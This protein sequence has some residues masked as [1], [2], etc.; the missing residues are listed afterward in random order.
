[1]EKP[2][3]ED[4]KK[5]I[6]HKNSR[7]S[8]FVLKHK[9]LIPG[10][11]MDINAT[12]MNGLHSAWSNRYADA[13]KE[14]KETKKGP[15][16]SKRF[17]TVIW[18]EIYSSFMRRKKTIN[19]YYEEAINILTTA[20]TPAAAHVCQLINPTNSNVS[21]NPIPPDGDEDGSTQ[22]DNDI[23]CDANKDND[24][25][26]P[27]L[28]CPVC[29]PPSMSTS[30]EASSSNELLTS[31][32]LSLELHAPGPN[33]FYVDHTDISERFYNMQQY[34]FNFTKVNNLTLESDVHL[35]L[36]LSSILL[37]Q[38][39]NRLHKDMI[40]FFG[41]KIY[42]K[43]RKS[44]LDSLNMTY[45]FPRETLLEII[46]TAQSVYNKTNNRINAAASLLTLANAVDDPIDKKLIVSASQLLQFLPMD[47][48]YSNIRETK[49]I[50]R[51][52]IH[53]IQPLFDDHERDIRLEFTF[54]EPADNY[55][56]EV[57]FT[58][59][60][61]CII[62][63]F[64][65]QTDDGVNVGYGEVKSQAMVG[66][67]Y[68]VNLDLMRLATLG[69]NSINENELTGNMS[70]H[71]VGPFITFYLIQLNADGLY[72]MTELAHVQYP[73][74]VS[75]V[76]AYLTNFSN[77]KNV[78]HVFQSFCKYEDTNADL[79]SWRRDSLLA[80]D[81]LYSASTTIYML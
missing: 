43:A 8:N 37:L 30:D 61:D 59:C 12:S 25:A 23:Y 20:A 32:P 31:T 53:A 40:P 18:S 6:R 60:P 21:N 15:P 56:R 41:D 14:V 2:W 16:K 80:T 74:S 47:P 1:M 81:D 50:T 77:L 7:F 48:T 33:R 63:V 45:N 10:W 22:S 75:E 34:V 27:I 49:L 66:D 39:N 64:P 36:S 57:S 5:Y 78:L 68:L 28:I 44:I 55:N 42:Q 79:S 17:N 70:I 26:T 29:S 13:Y 38:N 51:Y 9:E 11:S 71:I 58:G 72:C 65:H 19:V 24:T 35:I 62:T 67:H 4:L 73:M 54:T 3:L 76:P 69:K 46:E 52:I